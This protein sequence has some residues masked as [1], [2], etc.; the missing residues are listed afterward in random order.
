MAGRRIVS[1]DV[2]RGFAV[3]GILLMNIFGFAFPGAAYLNPAYTGGADP[4]NLGLW[5]V[6]AVAVDGKMRALFA[7]LFGASILLM[8]EGAGAAAPRRHVARMA[9]LF[10]IGMLHAWFLWSG[11]ILVP[12]AIVG[13]LV[14][15]ARA[16]APSRL[17]LLAVAAL[18]LQ[19]A[20]IASFGFAA[21]EAE[22]AAAAAGATTAEIELWQSMAGVIRST[23]EVLSEDRAAIQGS[24]AEILAYRFRTTG[25]T[26]GV[27]FPFFFFAETVGLMLAGMAL[28]RLGWWQ[29][30]LAPGR[31][32]RVALV[33]IAAGWAVGAVLAWRLAASGFHPATYYFTDSVRVLV[34]PVVALGYSALLIAIVQ[35]GALPRL[36]GLLAN[37]GR[38][39]LTNYLLASLLANLMFTG[40]GLGLYGRL[41]RLEALLVVLAIWAVQLA[42]STLWLRRFRQGPAEWLWRSLARWE[43]QPMRVAPAQ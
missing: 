18:A 20:I 6:N 28:Y 2:V 26:Q 37:A 9:V 29:A 35:A 7:M 1:I 10:G 34:A 4:L 24:L 21:R 17:L 36:S 27:V 11:D 31:Y 16:F 15:P 42:F 23:P 12:Y 39:A 22:A 13:L 30:G 43:R 41:T 32:R 33:A 25:F 8:A 5:A 40:V 3:L 38:M 19:A 14:F